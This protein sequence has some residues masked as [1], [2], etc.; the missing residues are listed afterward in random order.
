MRSGKKLLPVLFGLL[1]VCAAAA[2]QP[3]DILIGQVAPYSGPLAS[4]GRDLGVGMETWFE[5]MNKKGGIRGRKI[6]LLKDNDEYKAEQ[7][8]SKAKALLE[9]NNVLAF[10]SFAGTANLKELIKSKLL[11]EYGIP[12]IGGR[13]GA[14]R[15]HDPYIFH[16]KGS[17]IDELNEI[18]RHCATIGINEVSVL[19]QDDAFGQDGLNIVDQ[20]AKQYGV[21]ILVRAGYEKNTTKVEPAVEA[22]AASKSQAVIMISNTAASSAFIQGVRK[23]GF[24]AMLLT[25]SVTDGEQVYKKIGEELSRGLVVSQLFPNPYNRKTAIVREFQDAV[26]QSGVEGATINYTVLEGYLTAKLLTYALEKTPTL[27]RAN[28]L[29]SLENV[30]RVDFGGFVFDFSNSKHEGAHFVDLSI[31]SRAGRI[32]Q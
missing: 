12:L 14:V 31:V 24:D 17:Y 11:S 27:T 5:Q 3:D 25:L 28:L 19:Y 2:A 4:V 10:A 23:K 16:I 8:V 20:Y 9:K 30:N 32:M 29:K 22:I 21:K 26:K 15:E 7:T 6:R 13:T 18:V 1:F